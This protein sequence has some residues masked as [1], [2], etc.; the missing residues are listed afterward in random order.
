MPSDTHWAGTSGI[1]PCVTE[2]EV[3]H[4]VE[5]EVAGPAG[6]EQHII[7]AVPAVSRVEPYA[8][9]YRPDTT[10]V[11]EQT[12]TL[13]LFARTGIELTALLFEL[14]EPAYICT[15]HKPPLRLARRWLGRQL[16]HL[17]S[18]TRRQQAQAATTHGRQPQQ[19]SFGYIHQDCLRNDK[20]I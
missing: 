17:I 1:G 12:H 2:M 8:Q 5:T 6:L 14:R 10:V 16:C 18:T 19:D 3:N 13:L 20:R 7:G 9:T 4:Q 15:S 11:T